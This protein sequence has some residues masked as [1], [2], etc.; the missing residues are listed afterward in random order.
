MKII[1]EAL[2]LNIHIKD[3][4]PYENE[5]VIFFDIETTGFHRDYSQLYLLGYVYFE[6]NV[7]YVEQHL[8]ENP[9]EELEILKALYQLIKDKAV[10]IT[11]NGDSFDFPYVNHKLS[12]YELPPVDNYMSIDIYK[13]VKKYKTFLGLENYK[14]KTIEKLVGIY[15]EDPYTGGDLI[16]QYK[17]YTQTKDSDLE[18]NLLLHNKEDMIALLDLMAIYDY[19][20]IISEIQ[21]ATYVEHEILEN[22]VIIHYTFRRV[23][24]IKHVVTIKDMQM[25]I[26]GNLQVRIPLIKDILFYFIKDYKNYYYIPEKDEV[27]HKNMAAFL[28]NDMKQ[29][30]KASNCY[31][32]H[33]STFLPIYDV[34]EGLK[35]FKKSRRDKQEYITINLFKEELDF[36]ARHLLKALKERN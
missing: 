4:I 32:K 16:E 20:N 22:H 33:E 11:Y 3:Y 27:I 8:A 35:I 14:L 36:Y 9:S 15:R 24:S 29:K 21:E 17:I 1:K 31:I 12:S 7:W 34:F 18:Y 30:A 6:K 25:L 13:D 23:P 28:P 5:D 26:D 10:V 19:L 2:N